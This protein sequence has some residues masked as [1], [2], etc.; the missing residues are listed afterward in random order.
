M[1]GIA[2]RPVP[3]EGLVAQEGG[4]MIHET[5]PMIECPDLFP[6]E[7][8]CI[9][10]NSGVPDF[11]PKTSGPYKLSCRIFLARKHFSQENFAF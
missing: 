5:F 9:Q 11:N 6:P 1:G 3:L 8:I 2:L 4:R 10:K 7:F